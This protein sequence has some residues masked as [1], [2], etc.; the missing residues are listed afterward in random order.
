M[1]RKLFLLALSLLLGLG[2]ATSPLRA[3]QAYKSDPIDPTYVMPDASKFDKSKKDQKTELT[4]LEKAVKAARS[5]SQET[6]DNVLRGL[7][8][9]NAVKAEFDRYYN[10]FVLPAMTQVDNESLSK[11]GEYRDELLGEIQDTPND[12]AIRKHMLEELV[13]PYFNRVAA[14]AGYHPA[15]RLNAVL[16]IGGLNRRDGQRNVE[17]ALPMELA[18]QSLLQIAA[19]ADSPP[20]LKIGAL[21][22]ILRHATIDGQLSPP[23][24]DGNL[25]NR[26]IDLSIAVLDATAPVADGPPLTDDQYWMRRQAVQILGAFRTPG[27]DGKAV[28]ALRKILDD[29]N[30]PLW[31]GA[32]VIEAYGAMRFANP[33]QAEVAKVIK[34]I[35][36][37][38]SRF[39]KADVQSIDDYI[40]GIKENRMI[41]KKSTETDKPAADA[42]N[43]DTEGGT[44][45]GNITQGK[46][47]GDK[48]GGAANL[49]QA[50][51]AGNT[52][53][54]PI[55][56][57][58]DVR[59]R[60]KTIAFVARTA[61]D[62]PAPRRKNEVKQ[63]ENL[64]AFADPD[65]AKV[66]DELV[67]AL[68]K[69]MEQTDLAPPKAPS[70][71]DALKTGNKP[72]KPETNDERLRNSLNAAITTVDSVIGVAPAE[73]AAI[74]SS[75]G[76]Q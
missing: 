27:T 16:V 37:I 26:A 40:A 21:S 42:G 15:V 46:G 36:M 23:V 1:S 63:P 47:A 49:N 55:Y 5:S 30:V 33:E 50:A 70:A 59:Q 61:L 31:L 48:G 2:I 54:V 53:E 73:P 13:L 68:D 66:I 9:I 24:M 67:A 65:T 62:G 69:V 6:A 19:A 22:G 60:A 57:I 56:K 34:P 11:L 4:N 38:A 32:D 17:P 8:D 29:P 20:Y 44:A 58:N 43:A 7:V 52:V 25:R 74:K 28:V 45:S 75:I 12:S 3:Q 76:G 72:Q 71:A 10:G 41:A 51:Q 39:F 64:K 14:D 35:G 18:L